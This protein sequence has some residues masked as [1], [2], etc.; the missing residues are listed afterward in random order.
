MEIVMHNNADGL[1]SPSIANQ[2]AETTAFIISDDISTRKDIYK[3]VKEVYSKRSAAVHGGSNNI[4]N[5]LITKA[6][7]IIYRLIHSILISEE[8]MALSNAKELYEWTMNRRFK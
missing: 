8:L 3:K 6:R 4:N 2:I 1:I 5:D 7:S